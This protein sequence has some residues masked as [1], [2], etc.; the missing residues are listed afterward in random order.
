MRFD[1]NNS[2]WL[3]RL[4]AAVS[5][6]LLVAAFPPLEWSVLAFVAFLPLLFVVRS[7][8]SGGAFRLGW[9]AGAAQWLVTV[10]WLHHVS[11]AAWVGLAF[12]CALYTGLFGMIAALLWRVCGASLL[13]R[14]CLPPVLAVAWGGL[15]WIRGTFATG[16]AWL[17]LAASQHENLA[18]LQLATWGGSY[19]VST[20]LMWMNVALAV[21]VHEYRL[22]RTAGRR[23]ANTT[24]LS[25]FLVLA[26]AWG[27][28]I[29]E[30]RTL[31]P[32]GPILKAALVQ[33]GIPQMDKWTPEMV[34]TIYGRLRSLTRGALAAEK[35]DLVIWPETAVPD[36]IRT[37]TNSYDVVLGL[38]TNGAPILLG[39]TD[40]EYRDVE[41]PRYFNS[42]FLFNTNGVIVSTYDKQHLVIFGEY[43]PLRKEFPPLGWLTPIE[44]S[45]TPGTTSRVFR[46]EYPAVGFS[47]LIC[48]EDTVADVARGFVLAGAQLLVNMSNDAWFDPSSCSRQHMLHSVLRAVENR[49]P[50]LRSCNTGVS[51]CIDR[52]GHV[53][54]TATDAQGRTSGAAFRNTLVSLPPPGAPQ[55][56]YTRHG[57]WFGP[58]AAGV[59]GI[60]VF[61]ALWRRKK[62]TD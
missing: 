22:A 9:F 38:V 54:D 41:K 17:P 52:F 53:Y 56:F 44:D 13:G 12:Y 27:H 29:R 20:L 47:T 26:L 59:A 4:G 8:V 10:F 49:V 34:D 11:W 32:T 60:L 5:G 19:L 21:T 42:T 2:R 50:V 61:V 14:F 51:C 33:P 18:L 6:L 1:F 15:E 30:M 31:Q 24:A 43:I 39:S 62:E 46:L 48:F 55:T 7:E 3:L 57:D 25:A 58:G 36:D 35:A 37:S 45:F 16:F 40:T 23:P 28:G